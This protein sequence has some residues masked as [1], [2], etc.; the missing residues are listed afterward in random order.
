MYQMENKFLAMRHLVNVFF[1][2]KVLCVD[3]KL[4][5]AGS[6]AQLSVQLQRRY[7]IISQD[8]RDQSY[9]T[10]KTT[11][12][13]VTVNNL[14]PGTLYI[15]QIRTSSSLDY[16]NSSPSVEVKT[17]AERKCWRCSARRARTRRHGLWAVAG[18]LLPRPGCSRFHG[19]AS[20]PLALS[21]AF[22]CIFLLEFHKAAAGQHVLGCLSSFFS[23]QHQRGQPVTGTDSGAEGGRSS[24]GTRLD[25]RPRLEMATHP[26]AILACEALAGLAAWLGVVSQHQCC[27]L[28][29]LTVSVHNYSPEASYFTD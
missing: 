20:V 16:G 9:S 6:T 10:V 19:A 15:F 4:C 18:T 21:A 22:N 7:L 11:S 29:L 2:V 25:L 14:K 26:M 23:G 12:T 24:L 13:A 28:F 27:L 1:L 3:R 5:C 17:L 8:Q